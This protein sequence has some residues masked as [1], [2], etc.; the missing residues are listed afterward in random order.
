MGSKVGLFDLELEGLRL[1]GL[2]WAW[3]LRSAR[4]MGSFPIHSVTVNVLPASRPHT[5]G[6]YIYDAVGGRVRYSPGRLAR[7]LQASLVASS[8]HP[9]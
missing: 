7:I 8:E 1:C 9:F 2:C 6:K 5:S 4:P 3:H